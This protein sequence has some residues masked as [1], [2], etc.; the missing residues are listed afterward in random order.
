MLKYAQVV[1]KIPYGDFLQTIGEDFV[2]KI[3]DSKVIAVGISCYELLFLLV[4]TESGQGFRKKTWHF[5][6]KN[7][8]FR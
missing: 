8:F 2:R 3:Q 7:N 5:L 4:F 6:N 1:K